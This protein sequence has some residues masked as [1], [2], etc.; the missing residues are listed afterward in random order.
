M[1]RD[2][3]SLFQTQ[4]LIDL[5]TRSILYLSLAHFRGS[6]YVST[7]WHQLIQVTFAVQTITSPFVESAETVADLTTVRMSALA[8][9]VPFHKLYLAM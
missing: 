2:S 1:N 7:D 9:Q 3:S 5:V 6:N 4:P 8:H